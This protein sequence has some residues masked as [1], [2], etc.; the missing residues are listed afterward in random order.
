[1]STLR[2]SEV[3]GHWRDEITT[4]STTVTQGIIDRTWSKINYC[5]NV[6]QE[7]G[8]SYWHIEGNIKTKRLPTVSFGIQN[9]NLS[10]P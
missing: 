4:A 10:S 9:G 6:F 5:L 2:N 3:Y 1:M 8:Y 7:N